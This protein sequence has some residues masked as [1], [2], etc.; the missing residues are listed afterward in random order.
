MKGAT[1][2]ITLALLV[3]MLGGSPTS[4]MSD[5]GTSLA[6]GNI[7]HKGM[8]TGQTEASNSSASAVTVITMT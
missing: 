5:A 7:S 2:P 4:A 1:L 6:D 8:T 3:M